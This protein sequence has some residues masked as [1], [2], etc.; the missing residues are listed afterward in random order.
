M[1]MVVVGGGE[2]D[3]EAAGLVVVEEWARK[4]C[5]GFPLTYLTICF[6]WDIV[7]L[8]GDHSL[9]H[10]SFLTYECSLCFCF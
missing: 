6:T 2:E 7:K 3:G 8:A 4:A 9:K 1:K 5:S 10:N